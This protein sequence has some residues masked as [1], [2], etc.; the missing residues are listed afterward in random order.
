MACTNC[1]QTTGFITGFNP[2]SCTS[3][4]SCY[5]NASCIV[6][7]GP[8][9]NCS[10][11]LTNDSLDIMLQKIDPLLCAATGDYSTYNTFCLAPIATQKEF[12]ESI[13]NFVCVLRNDFNTF[14]GTTFPAYQTSVTAAISAVNHPGI[15]CTAASVVNTDTIPAVLNKYCTAITNINSSIDLSS[16]TWGSCY[17]VSPTP[18]TVFQ[19]FN[20]LISQICLLKNQVGTGGA[21]PTFNNSTNCLAGTTDDSLITTINSITARLCSTGTINTTTLTW[22]CIAQPSG[23]QNLQGTI[24]NILTQ[25]TTVT[26]AEPMVWSADFTVTNVDNGNL[27][28]GK[29]IAL[30]TPS[31]QDRF[32]ASTTSDT[33]PGVLQSKLTAGTDISLDFSTTPG[34]VIINNTGGAGTGDHKVLADGSDTIPDYLINKIEASP[35]TFGISI[36]P[37][38]DV[39]NTS[40]QVSL[41]IGVDL[42]TLFTSLLQIVA[43]DSGLQTLFCA[44]VNACPSPCAPPSNVTVTYNSASSTTTTTT[45]TM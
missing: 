34:Q 4:P 22:G 39:T 41:N 15:T 9:L 31:T 27:C 25:L 32:V 21:L 1:I 13:S 17:V 36:T 18:T 37:V 30:A 8:A 23:A 40:H 2:A 16:V 19:G 28:L 11:I 33:S 38:I 45:T 10:G 6:Y 35:A 42:V 20:T 12:V 29:N 44:T 5:Q 43:T 26:Q 3:L 14:T 7:T 24:Q